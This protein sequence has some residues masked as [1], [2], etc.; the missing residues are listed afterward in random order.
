MHTL[1]ILTI[2]IFFYRN[3]IRYKKNIEF[4]LY[5]NKFLIDILFYNTNT[6]TY[7]IYIMLDFID[8]YI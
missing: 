5:L 6:G 3:N 8:I 1:H 4:S 7:L 2:P